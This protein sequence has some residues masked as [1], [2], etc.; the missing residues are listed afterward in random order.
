MQL[1][2]L[3]LHIPFCTHRCSYCDFNTYSGL[4][5][6][7]PAYI[8]ALCREIEII[9]DGLESTIPIHTIYLGGGTPSLLPASS[10]ERIVKSIATSFEWLAEVELTLEANPGTISPEYLDHIQKL[11]VNRLSL[12]MQSA[13]PGELRLLERNHGYSDVVNA[14]KWARQAA[15]DNINLDLIFG[16]PYQTVEVWKN[17][18]DLAI[19]L[20]PAHFSLYAL[21]LEK[22]TLMNQ[23]VERGRLSQP[24]PDLAA[25]MYEWASE[26]LSKAGY[27]QYEI[28]NW[29]LETSSGE[30]YM[31]K[32]NL[33][34]WRNL[35]YLGLGAGAHGF[36]NGFRTVN[37]YLPQMYIQNLNNHQAYP[38]P[39]TLANVH[40]QPI[41]VHT[42]MTETMLMGLRLTQEGVSRAGFYK[43]F[44]QRLEQVFSEEIHSLISQGL[45]EWAGDCEEIL[46]LTRTGRLLGNQ[47]FM[48]F[49]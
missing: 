45:L 20:Q 48:Q 13:S 49:V 9:A 29:G 33:Q 42:E 39:Q 27:V 16:L 35:P 1:Y 21:T 3:Y 26:R 12:G 31:C 5:G 7:I 4:D 2:S 10:L 36:A 47:V 24:D 17:N 11:G 43:R 32:H 28:S 46:R 6:I 19:N 18:L 25:E 44:E 15:I 30:I 37:T 41:D 8:D 22:G 38:F 23:W 40:L 14:V 34:Y